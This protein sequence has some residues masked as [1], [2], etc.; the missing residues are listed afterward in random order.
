MQG[1]SDLL[2]ACNQVCVAVCCG[3]LQC[4]AVCCGVLQ[5]AAVC[6]SVLQC[7]AVC[8]SVFLNTLSQQVIEQGERER[9]WRGAGS[10]GGREGEREREREKTRESVCVR[11]GGG[12]ERDT[13]RETSIFFYFFP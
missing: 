7:V 5:C 2:L 12:R 13:Q 1:V 6:C 11:R 4:V 10:C 3:V 9:G 8:C